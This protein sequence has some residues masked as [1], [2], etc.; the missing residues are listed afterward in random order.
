MSTQAKSLETG[1]LLPSVN[2]QYK[3]IQTCYAIRALKKRDRERNEKKNRSLQDRL[4][5]V[6]HPSTLSYPS[7]QSKFTLSDPFLE[8]RTVAQEIQP[9][10][11]IFLG[12]RVEFLGQ[13]AWEATEN[14]TIMRNLQEKTERRVGIQR[15][16][17]RVISN[18]CA[19]LHFIIC[20]VLSVLTRRSFLPHSFLSC[21]KV[22]NLE[23][24]TLH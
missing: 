13:F 21:G 3:I 5:K 23:H 8:I 17:S 20:S 14:I 10:E 9:S 16:R 12:T 19:L 18:G 1:R 15:E 4:F 11:Q 24:F 7:H 22:H 2:R 6:G